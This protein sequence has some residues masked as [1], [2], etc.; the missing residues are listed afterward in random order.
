MGPGTE[1]WTKRARAA[2]W[3]LASLALALVWVPLSAPAGEL[4]TLPREQARR[5]TALVEEAQR[6]REAERYD[7][8]I[9]KLEEALAAYPAPAIHYNL[10][11]TLEDAG[12]LARAVAAYEACLEAEPSTEV[13]EYAEKGLAR[14]EER[15]AT[16]PPAE[17]GPGWF[18]LGFSLGEGALFYDGEVF[19]SLELLPQ[20]RLGWFG[21]ELGTTV[22]V[23]PTA[24][25]LLRPGV[26]FQFGAPYLRVS[27]PLM[28]TPSVT[29]G[30]AVAVG[31]EF[32]VA[33]GW[34][35]FLEADVLLWWEAIEVVLLE[36]RFGV[37]Y[38]F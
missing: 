18:H 36:G 19:R 6:L 11:R 16:A 29:A 7:E 13:R 32:R 25:V 8:A 1:R 22:F 33:G 34:S 12:H 5:V 21:V 20:A 9:E 38:A 17:P 2:G 37:S 14:L 30:G 10:A 35:L 28:L 3:L 24:A 26:R 23:E 15:L 31:G 4:P 27:L